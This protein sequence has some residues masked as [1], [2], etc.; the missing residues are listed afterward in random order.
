MIDR[1]SNLGFFEVVSPT[2]LNSS[3][4]GTGLVGGGIFNLI[5]SQA[6]GRVAFYLDAA[7]ASVIGPTLIVTLQTATDNA[8]WSNVSGAQ[9]A[10]V[11]NVSTTGGVQSIFVDTASLSQYNRIYATVTGTTPGFVVSVVAVYPQKNA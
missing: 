7:S 10:T 1:V 9:F 11:T 4:A 3:A 8:T 6:Q 5:T 2:T